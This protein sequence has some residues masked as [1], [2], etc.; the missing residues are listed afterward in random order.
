[1]ACDVFAA[2]LLTLFAATGARLQGRSE[3]VLHTP[4]TSL[5][6]ET[7]SPVDPR[8]EEPLA[9]ALCIEPA[10]RYGT[11]SELAAAV[12]QAFGVPKAE[13]SSPLVP[14][15]PAAPSLPVS[16]AV[17]PSSEL[18]FATTQPDPMFV[19]S[20]HPEHSP[21]VSG[22]RKG[23]RLVL[24][25]AAVALALG[26][27]GLAGWTISRRGEG[28]VPQTSVASRGSNTGLVPTGAATFDTPPPAMDS[29]SP[30]IAPR[31]GDARRPAQLT[32]ACTPECDVVTVD[33]K[34][35]ASFPITVAPGTH[36]A[37]ARRGRH[38]L[39]TKRFDMIA[40]EDQTVSFVFFAPRPP[41]TSKKPCG[42]F[43]QRCD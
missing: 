32:V 8:W 41:P 17:A 28:R 27:I 12:A 3:E 35:V 9:R 42:K 2:A 30:T 40:S 1:M 33:G 31:D 13:P 37:T 21:V 10:E 39:Q 25:G 36:T 14:R 20:P 38:P 7:G 24:L 11:V 34:A 22:Q 18:G 16:A 6:R 15:P 19:A 26:A 29:A 5:A 43:L 23:T 4:A